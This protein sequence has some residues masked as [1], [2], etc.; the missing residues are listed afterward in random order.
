ML[1]SEAVLAARGSRA[2]PY[3]LMVEHAA[4]VVEDQVEFER[5]REEADAT[6][7]LVHHLGMAADR[8]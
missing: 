3:S 8:E 4:I 5:P 1:G 7:Q 2:D 6:E